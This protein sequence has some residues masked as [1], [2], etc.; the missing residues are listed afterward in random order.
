MLL[1]R[2]TTV[3]LSRG[4]LHYISM[5]ID[6]LQRWNQKVSL[7]AIRDPQ[8]MV[9]RHFGESLFAAEQLFGPGPNLADCSQL[10]IA[11]N[12]SA[13][14]ALR[15]SVPSAALHVVDVG[16]GAG[17]PGIPLKIWAPAIRLTLVEST[18][19]KATFL[20]EVVR[21]LSLMD[22]EVYSGRAEQFAETADVVTMRAVERF[23]SVLPTAAR[24]VRPGGRIAL[25]IGQKQ[26]ASAKKIM[27]GADWGEPHRI[28]QSESR[29]VAI[30]RL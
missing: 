7:T 6:I 15:I 5:Y 10:A 24:L 29:V 21:T 18:Q 26:F 12:D 20:R 8:E 23:A 2:F 9:A 30:G 13:Q 4:Q 25:L 16:S 19:K 28:P 27:A 22:V 14:S 3:P 17:F 1:R 11:S